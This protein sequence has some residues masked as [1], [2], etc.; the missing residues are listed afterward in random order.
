MPLA[1]WRPSPEHRPGTGADAG[2]LV[3]RADVEDIVRQ[4]PAIPVQV[5]PLQ[6]PIFL[7]E[8]L[9]STTF[10]ALWINSYLLFVREPL[11]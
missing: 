7:R 8:M 2:L 11:C 10:T 9:L 5:E 4:P 6:P 1:D 3:G